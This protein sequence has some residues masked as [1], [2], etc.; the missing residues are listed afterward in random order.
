VSP[1]FS[2]LAHRLRLG[3]CLCLHFRLRLH[4]SQRLDTWQTSRLVGSECFRHRASIVPHTPASPPFASTC[5]L[6][7]PPPPR[8]SPQP[9]HLS[10]VDRN[11]TSLRRGRPRRPPRRSDFLAPPRSALAP[12]P[13]PPPPPPP[14]A[15][16]LRLAVLEM[17]A[18]VN[19]V[20][21]LSETTPLLPAPR[22]RRAASL[23]SAPRTPRSPRSQAYNFARTA[24]AVCLLALV[25]AVLVGT[26][27]AGWHI[28]IDG[29]GGGG[30]QTGDALSWRMGVHDEVGDRSGSC[31]LATRG[32]VTF[33]Y[34]PT[35]AVTLHHNVLS[36]CPIA[37]NALALY[38]DTSRD[39]KPQRPVTLTSQGQVLSLCTHTRNALPL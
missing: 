20:R 26:Y 39:F 8:A 15:L 36:A 2:G 11:L 28:A 14:S 7:P 4:V 5:G 37:I 9:R 29:G 17:A 3:S 27:L 24:A 22:F 33:Y 21:I 12:P 13:L 34:A 35:R 19:T 6:G 10:R 31:Y 23:L 30:A 32:S 18:N 16:A 25:V 38:T 1:P